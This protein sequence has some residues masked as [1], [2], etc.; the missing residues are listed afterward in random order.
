MTVQVPTA[1]PSEDVPLSLCLGIIQKLA[2]ADD[3]DKDLLTHFLLERFSGRPEAFETLLQRIGRSLRARHRKDLAALYLDVVSPLAEH[4]GM[5]RRK[6]KL[7]ALCFRITHPR[8]SAEVERTLEKYKKESARYLGRITRALRSALH[9]QYQCA[10]YGRFKEPYSV[11]LKF[12]DKQYRHMLEL[13]D[14]FAF[15]IILESND[16]RLCFDVLDSLHKRFVPV[17]GHFKDYIRTPKSNGYQSLHTALNRIIPDLDL[18][19]EVQIRTRFMHDFSQTGLSSHWLYKKKGP[20]PV[21]TGSQ[22]ALLEHTL[23]LTREVGGK[24][25]VYCLSGG[26]LLQLPPGATAAHA[27][28]ALDLPEASAMSAKVNGARCRTDRLLRDGDEI[29]FRRAA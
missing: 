6:R 5:F 22:R 26:R 25:H 7:D 10:I 21:L 12:R 27:A 3:A 2:K 9:P 14:I 13:R 28:R 19:T 17:A 29:A 16:D 24:Q 4:F 20:G 8:E 1:R 23:S 18:P 15:R 11:Y